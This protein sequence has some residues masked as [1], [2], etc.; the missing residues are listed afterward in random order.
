[1]LWQC[2]SVHQCC[3]A[4]TWTSNVF[5]ISF[6]AKSPKSKHFCLA[7]QGQCFRLQSVLLQEEFK[8]DASHPLQRIQQTKVSVWRGTLKRRRKNCYVMQKIF[9]VTLS[10]VSWGYNSLTYSHSFYHSRSWRQD[11][12]TLVCQIGKYHI[13]FF[14]A[15]WGCK[16][17]VTVL[18]E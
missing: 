13:Y 6:W 8:D 12:F 18:W 3:Y 15:K 4:A 7:S 17:N 16:V 9:L 5:Q 11:S 14:K 1:M 10:Y 2:W